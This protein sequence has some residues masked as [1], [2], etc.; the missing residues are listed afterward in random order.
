MRQIM[1]SSGW[2]LRQRDPSRDLATQIDED[3]GW[4]PATVPGVVHHDL[5]AAGLLPDPFEG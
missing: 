2:Q 4:I 5:I 1:L 3:N